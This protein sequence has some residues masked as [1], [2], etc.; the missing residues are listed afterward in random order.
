M[1]MK[2]QLAKWF[3]FGL[4]IPLAPL[5]ATLMVLEST[6]GAASLVAV[7]A[8]G[9][10]VLIGVALAARGV[11]ELLPGSTIAGTSILSAIGLSVVVILAGSVYYGALSVQAVTVVERVMRYSMILYMC[12]ITTSFACAFI[13]KKVAD[14]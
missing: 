1:Q 4:L 12:A 8:Q 5:A 6:K 14:A 11:G 7:M 2:Q 3:V 13:A 9:Q 10:L